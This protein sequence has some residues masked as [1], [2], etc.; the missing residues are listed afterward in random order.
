MVAIPPELPLEVPPE[1]PLELLAMAPSSP[2]PPLSGVLLDD[3]DDEQATTSVT[4]HATP[5][6]AWEGLI[7]TPV[8][9][10][11][12]ALQAPIGPVFAQVGSGSEL[13][14]KPRVVLEQQPHVRNPVAD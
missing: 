13:R 6:Q 14:Q 4:L 1:L 5:N 7:R 8:P 9:C 3:E 11:C 2:P 12:P 10:L